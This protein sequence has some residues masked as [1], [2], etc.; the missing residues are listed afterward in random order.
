MLTLGC[1]LIQDC[2]SVSALTNTVICYLHGMDSTCDHVT[3][4]QT[5]MAVINPEQQLHV[6]VSDFNVEVIAS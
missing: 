5:V 1:S 6:L 3:V 2:N 4:L